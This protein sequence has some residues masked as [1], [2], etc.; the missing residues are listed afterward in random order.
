MR[1]LSKVKEECI[2]SLTEEKLS[3]AAAVDMLQL[4]LIAASQEVSSLTRHS[5]HVPI[6]TMPLLLLMKGAGERSEE[7]SC[8][9]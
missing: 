9:A 3:S 4:R 6:F 5:C 1:C 7:S 8:G 2:E